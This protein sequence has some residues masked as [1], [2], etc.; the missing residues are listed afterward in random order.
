MRFNRTALT[1]ALIAAVLVP[2]ALAASAPPQKWTQRQWPVLVQTQPRWEG[3]AVQEPSV[4]Y[5]NGRYRMWYTS[6]KDVICA[7]GYAE[8]TDGIT[9][10]KHNGPIRGYHQPDGMRACHNTIVLLN[11]VYYLYYS[12]IGS[13]GAVNNVVTDPYIWVATSRDGIHFGKG[14]RVLGPTETAWDLS[15]TAVF[16][17]GHGRW[18]MLVDALPKNNSGPWTMHLASS[19]SPL[20]PFRFVPDTDAS[21]AVLQ[22]NGGTFGAPWMIRQNGV[23]RLWYLTSATPGSVLPTDIY[24][25][26]SRDLKTWTTPQMVLTRKNSWEVD[27]VADPSVVTVKGVTRMYY[28]GLW[29]NTNNGFDV[30]GGIG[31]A[32]LSQ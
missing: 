19:R 11:N 8:S 18:Y 29:N 6:G 1:A 28:A 2:V 30:L 4:L 14:H 27:Q 25:S 17:D 15:N 16:N 10:K 32:T 9:W 12:T 22:V 3:S 5:V 13:H 26:E 31:M 7:L 20:G 24:Y 21:L 23:Y